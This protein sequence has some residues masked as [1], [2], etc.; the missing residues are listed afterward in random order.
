M[1]SFESDPATEPED[2]DSLASES[3]SFVANAETQV[4]FI[5]GYES[6]LN[7]L[8][9]EKKNLESKI[10]VRTN[11]DLNKNHWLKAGG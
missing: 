5:P 6:E 10:Q 1:S 3:P 2:P 4:T 9:E 8:R 11:L 7:G